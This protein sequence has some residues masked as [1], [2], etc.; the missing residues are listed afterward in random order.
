VE[1]YGVRIL[2]TDI[3]QPTALS[4]RCFSNVPIS[5]RSFRWEFGRVSFPTEPSLYSYRI[6]N[7][8]S[9]I[10]LTIKSMQ[11][12]FILT[13]LSVII[14]PHSL[15]DRMGRA[16]HKSPPP[17]PYDLTPLP[18][19]VCL[20]SRNFGDVGLLVLIELP[21]PVDDVPRPLSTTIQCCSNAVCWRNLCCTA[22]LS[23]SCTVKSSLVGKCGF[24]K[25]WP[26][27]Q[28]W[29]LNGLGFGGAI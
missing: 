1:N 27:V 22:R 23:L 17:P 26:R 5:Q 29:R 8:S 12:K 16:A 24:E 3:V 9:T 13:P 14:A 11:Q 28:G 20:K 4:K 19:K 18:S 2:S 15:R 21:S 7:I 25:C 6:H 10:W